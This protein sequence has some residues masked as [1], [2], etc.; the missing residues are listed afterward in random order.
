MPIDDRLPDVV[1]VDRVDAPAAVGET[2][3]EVGEQ[4][5]SNLVDAADEACVDDDYAEGHSASR[6]S[7]LATPSHCSL[8]SFPLNSIQ[9]PRPSRRAIVKV[10]VCRSGAAIIDAD[11]S[12]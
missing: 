9:I 8:V 4:R 10:A 11:A 1:W 3:Q 2:A 12:L 5:H 6:S 7:R